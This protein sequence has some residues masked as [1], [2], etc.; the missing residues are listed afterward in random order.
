MPSPRLTYCSVTNFLHVGDEY[1]FLRRS[2]TKKIDAGRL[3]GIGGKV[4]P[5]EDF[6]KA[7]VRETQEETGYIISPH[8]VKLAGVGKI[9]GGYEENWVMSFFTIEV[10]KK[11]IPNGFFSEEGTFLWIHKDNVLQSEYE[12]VDDLKICFPKIAQ[13]GSIF[14]FQAT[15]NDQEKVAEYSLSEVQP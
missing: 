6:L 12:I 14:F 11:E 8:Q 7:A 13:G 4:E 5:G 9:E 15:M 2:D 1:L 3:N 10:E